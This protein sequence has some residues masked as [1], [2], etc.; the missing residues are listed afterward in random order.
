MMPLLLKSAIVN[1]K[2]FIHKTQESF[3]NTCKTKETKHSHETNCCVEKSNMK[4][5]FK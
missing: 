4:A 2:L 1:I 3:S 5:I